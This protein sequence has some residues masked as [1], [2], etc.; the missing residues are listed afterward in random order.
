MKRFNLIFISLMIFRFGL[1]YSQIT[2]LRYENLNGACDFE[3]HQLIANSKDELRKFSGCN[4]LKFDFNRYT[5]IGVKGSSPGHFNPVINFRILKDDHNKK[6]T[7]EV[8]F[9]GGKTCNCRVVKPLYK[10]MIYV[11]KIEDDYNFEFKSVNT[12]D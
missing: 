4:F 2:E 7:I 10:R 8:L 3:S 5:I 11:D 12:D 9:S 1:S 6:V